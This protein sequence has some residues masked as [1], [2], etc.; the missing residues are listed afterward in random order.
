MVSP[1]LARDVT[2]RYE[3]KDPVLRGVTLALEP[4]SLQSLIG[5]NGSGKS[6]LLQLLSGWLHPEAGH[7]Q[8]HGNE[9]ASVAPRYRARAIAVLPQ[10][11]EMPHTTVERFVLGGRYAHLGPW[12]S[13]RRQDLDKV[14]EAMA[15]TDT[16]AWSQRLLAELSGGERQRVYVARALAQEASILL[17]DEPTASLDVDHAVEIFELLQGLTRAGRT[18][19]VVTHDLNLASLYSRTIHLL[20]RGALVASGPPDAILRP[21]ILGPV[22]GERIHYGHYPDGPGHG[23]PLLAPRPGSAAE[24]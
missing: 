15:T 16:T 17:C 3:D 12:R 23:R 10:S 14:K 11:R 21:E 8:L 19:F 1:L 4:G 9:L 24:A 2:F 6:T 13:V 18:V 7:V 5:P 20:H 22:H